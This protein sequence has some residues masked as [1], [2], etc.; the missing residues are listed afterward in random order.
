[1]NKTNKEKI[2]EMVILVNKLDN[3]RDALSDMPELRPIIMEQ[4]KKIFQADSFDGFLKQ[5]NDFKSI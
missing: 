4:A 5:T 3:L 2:I 1:M